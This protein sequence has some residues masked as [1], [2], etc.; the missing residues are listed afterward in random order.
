MYKFTTQ[1]F[2]YHKLNTHK[3]QVTCPNWQIL[4][5]PKSKITYVVQITIEEPLQI[6]N[7]AQILKTPSLKLHISPPNHPNFNKPQQ[8]SLNFHLIT[9]IMIKI[10][11]IK[12]QISKIKKL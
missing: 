1:I 8:F 2:R 3:L 7:F 9:T 10:K 5:T 4:K 11:N 12:Y 6:H